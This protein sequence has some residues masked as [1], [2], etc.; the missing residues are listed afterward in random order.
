MWG[1]HKTEA[2]MMAT[3]DICW[4]GNHKEDWSAWAAFH[5]EVAARHRG[6]GQSDLADKNE[7]VA[8]KYDRRAARAAKKAAKAVA[9]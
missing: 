6:G 8:Q 4:K 1:G 2:M 5:R 3:G 9:Q 7:E